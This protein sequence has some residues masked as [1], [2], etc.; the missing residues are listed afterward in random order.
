MKLPSIGQ[1]LHSARATFLRFP[2]VLCDA[3]IGTAAALLLVDYEGAAQPT[4]LF[5]ILF[6]SI[7]GLPLFISLLLL[8][9]H[10]RWNPPVT[11][12]I[13]IIG[14]LLL[15]GYALVT[16]EDYLNAPGFHLVRFLILAAALHLLVSVAPFYERGELNGFWHYNK[17]LFIRALTALLYTGVLWIGLAVA[18]EALDHLFGVTIPGKRYPELWI[19]LNGIFCTWFFLSGVPEDLRALESLT[20]Y[21]KGLKIF[22]QYILLPLVCV[23]LVILY[24][25]LLK[26]VI[27]W[28]W[29]Q[30]WVSKLILGF[31]GTG[32]FALLLLQPISNRTEQVWIRTASRWFYVVLSPLTV[33]LFFAV[34]RR[35]SEYGVTEGRYLAIV[36]GGWLVGMVAYFTVSRLKSIKVVPATLL[37]LLL[38][39][40]FG[41]WSIFAVSER[42]QV[43][44]LKTILSRD[45]IL[46][47]GKIHG[48]HSPVSFEDSKQIS[49]IVDYLHDLHGYEG[50]E[51]W[52]AETLKKDSLGKGLA[53]LGSDV[54]T[55]KMGVTYTNAWRSGARQDRFVFVDNESAIDVREFELLVRGLHISAEELTKNY[56][57]L[58]L[59]CRTSKQLD[60]ITFILAPGSRALDTLRVDLHQLL[61]RVM[62]DNAN[63]DLT[64]IPL[65]QMSVTAVGRQWKVKVMVRE[66]YV[67]WRASEQKAVWYNLD[68]LYSLYEKE[69]TIQ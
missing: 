39:V 45:S 65:E 61:R 48:S 27:S 20:E 18:L 6:A 21:P 53:A 51:P 9:E 28:D 5:P 63:A 50:I 31:S 58:G 41:P 35:V 17:T 4:I 37:I 36:L 62:E 54:V 43:G 59:S 64:K 7:L 11:F 26:V 14:L 22:A 2:V 15:V 10:K 24:A 40:S 56:P 46:V 30:G 47:D 12:G 3:V 8:A 25:Y 69:E 66:A 49:S 23:Y 19:L 29:P 55:G 1:L 60:T 67:K 16:P 32:I 57:R 33:M 34:W 38:A 42:S 44:R 68:I 13:H 52:F